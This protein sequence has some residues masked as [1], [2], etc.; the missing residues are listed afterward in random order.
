MRALAHARRLRQHS[1]GGWRVARKK[2][3]MREFCGHSR[4]VEEQAE[5]GMVMMSGDWRW[6]QEVSIKNN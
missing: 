1:A 4:A 2:R 3:R 5:S 6:T